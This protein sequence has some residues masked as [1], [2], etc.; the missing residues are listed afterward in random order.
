[1]VARRRMYRP[2]RSTDP[3]QLRHSPRVS[4]ASANIEK[5]ASMKQEDDIVDAADQDDMDD[6][7]APENTAHHG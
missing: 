2:L 6:A 1:M 5:S 3:E 7:S 4:I